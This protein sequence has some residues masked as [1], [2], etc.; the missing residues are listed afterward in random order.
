M[1]NDFAMTIHQCFQVPSETDLTEGW[2]RAWREVDSLDTSQI[3]ERLC[4]PAPS[5]AGWSVQRAEFAVEEYRRFLKLNAKYR[6]LRIVPSL[7]VDEVWHTHILDTRKYA[8]DCQRIFGYFLHH[9]PYFGLRGDAAVRDA[10]FDR[11]QLVYLNEFGP[12]ATFGR[13]SND[14]NHDNKSTSSE[15]G[16]LKYCPSSASHFAG[17]QLPAGCDS[18]D[19]HAAGCDAADV[20]PAGCDGA[21]VLAA[22]CDAADARPAGCDAADVRAAGCDAADVRPAGCDAADVRAAGC[23]AADVRP[24]GCD[25]ADVRAAGCDAADVRPAGCDGVGAQPLEPGLGKASLSVH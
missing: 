18:A 10:A 3:L 25:A 19:V 5:G 15:A 14:P 8:V 23:D 13:G 12:R 4:F 22:G 2:M 6:E 16:V 7:L 17:R 1:L 21:D 20:R 9:F 24:A 11:A